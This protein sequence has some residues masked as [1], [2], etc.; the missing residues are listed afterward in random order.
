MRDY[1]GNIE[2]FGKDNIELEFKFTAQDKRECVIWKIELNSSSTGQ[3][4]AFP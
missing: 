1:M 4:F 3:D 2:H